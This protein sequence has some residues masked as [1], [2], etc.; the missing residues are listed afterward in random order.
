MYYDK[1]ETFFRELVKY[2]ISGQLKVAPEHIVDEV[3]DKMG[4][5]KSAVYL[6]FAEKYM[7]NKGGK[8]LNV[9]S[10]A[11]FKPGPLMATYYA[12][13]SY[14]V[15]QMVKDYEKDALT[16]YVDIKV[17]DE[18][19]RSYYYLKNCILQHKRL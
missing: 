14:V 2:H 15:S 11:G 17:S 5:P 7:K 3:L 13:K 16:E 12:T 6:K 9:A 4:K 10:I 1:D 18:E 19:L 8:I